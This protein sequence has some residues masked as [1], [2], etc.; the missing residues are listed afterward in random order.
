MDWKH[1]KGPETCSGLH[2]R[3]SAEWIF[4]PAL[5]YAMTALLRKIDKYIFMLYTFS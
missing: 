3:G 4:G 2:T 5:F 1:V